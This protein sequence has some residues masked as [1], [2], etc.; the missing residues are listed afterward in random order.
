MKIKIIVEKKSG[1]NLHE[2]KFQKE[3]ESS[4]FKITDS[5]LQ[6]LVAWKFLK[7]VDNSNSKDYYIREIEITE[8]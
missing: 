7:K 4:I 1:E 2:G 5:E 6:K 8:E 3:N